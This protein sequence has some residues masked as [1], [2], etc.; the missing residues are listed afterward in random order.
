MLH[1]NPSR[2]NQ[3]PR[4]CRA[5]CAPKI[6]DRT[7]QSEAKR[8]RRAARRA[9]LPQCA[10][11]DSAGRP[12]GA[13]ADRRGRGGARRGPSPRVPHARLLPAALRPDAAPH[14]GDR[15]AALASCWMRVTGSQL[16]LST[17]DQ[18]PYCAIR[19]ASSCHEQG[20]IVLATSPDETQTPDTAASAKS[21]TGQTLR[22]P[23]RHRRPRP[24]GTGPRSVLG[25]WRAGTIGHEQNAVG[26]AD[27][28]V[29]SGRPAKRD[30]HNSTPCW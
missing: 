14:Q 18:Q 22:V 23:E 5:A 6:T 7:R 11:A 9:P 15:T 3:P 19:A 4:T 26:I 28:A 2:G 20:N 12:S 16:I 21:E 27:T 13:P 24:D 30:R 8:T 10:R 29:R 25:P 1:P 17:P